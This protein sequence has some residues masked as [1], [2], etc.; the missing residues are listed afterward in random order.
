MK[1]TFKKAIILGAAAAFAFSMAAVSF[2]REGDSG[3]DN[4]SSSTATSSDRSGETIRTIIEEGRQKIEDL[5]NQIKDQ[6][7]QLKEKFQSARDEFKSKIDEI[8]QD[9]KDLL[10]SI[11]E[12]KKQKT[13]EARN[14]AR[15]RA[16]E[17]A[18]KL[19][20]NVAMA[21]VNRLGALEN[22]LSG[23]KLL[24][25]DKVTIKAE[26]D[27][28]INWLNAK[29]IEI[30]NTASTS[31]TT[32]KMQVQEIRDY[33]DTVKITVKRV[34]GEIL[35]GRLNYIVSREE[36]LANTLA[37]DIAALKAAGKNT[38]LVE[39]QLSDAKARIPA[40][41]QKIA[42][43]MAQFKLI[44]SLGAIKTNYEAG[45]AL[46]KDARNMLDDVHKA[47]SRVRG[48][49]NSLRGNGGL[50][51]AT[52]TPPVATTTPPVATTTATTTP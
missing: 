51:T 47:L 40:V 15:G 13:E 3:N 23:S 30:G 36:T 39:S 8:N 46:V 20:G 48:A 41:K 17:G 21:L 9:R 35:A 49:I 31:A 22:K 44:T 45:Q 34:S 38:V 18:Q 29:V 14:K 52:T 16:V 28:N 1:D 12:I 10:T 5:K 7:D 42:D 43:A 19:A 25:T 27:T 2:A 6:R 26:I 33:S 37:S 11:G 4:S 32:T 24:D 50:D